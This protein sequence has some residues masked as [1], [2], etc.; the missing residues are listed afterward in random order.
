MR[1][2]FVVFLLILSSIIFPPLALVIVSIHQFRQSG[3]GGKIFWGSV[4]SLSSVPVAAISAVFVWFLAVN[5]P[6]TSGVIAHGFSPGG[7]ETCVVQTFTGAEYRVSLYARR[8][9]QP[10]IWH[11]LE[12]EGDRWRNCRMEFAGDQLRV[13]ADGTLRKTFSLADATSPPEESRHQLPAAFTPEQ[14]AATHNAES[15]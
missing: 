11:Y 4:G 2:E 7:D 14:I 8:T 15:P 12:H 13:Y 1:F 6:F 9:G 10:W 3:K 5:F